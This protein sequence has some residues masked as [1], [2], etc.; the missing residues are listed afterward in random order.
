MTS[1]SLTYFQPILFKISN[2]QKALLFLLFLILSCDLWHNAD[3]RSN[4]SCSHPTSAVIWFPT[5]TNRGI[6]EW[7]CSHKI[8]L[9]LTINAHSSCMY[10]FLVF[11]MKKNYIN[12]F[13]VMF[14]II[15]LILVICFRLHARTITI[16]PLTVCSNLCFTQK[17]RSLCSFTIQHSTGSVL[18]QR[19]A[20]N[21]AQVTYWSLLRPWSR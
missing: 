3:P 20:I 21:K 10:Y 19:Q 4:N 6:F 17:Q 8:I 18:F 7:V 12:F 9:I 14:W 16:S 5:T 2:Y 15:L 11:Q 13:F 1:A